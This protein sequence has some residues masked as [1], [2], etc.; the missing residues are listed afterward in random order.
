MPQCNTQHFDV[1][2]GI[3]HFLLHSVTIFSFACRS[4]FC[5]HQIFLYHPHMRN[6][7]FQYYVI[8]HMYTAK[9][10]SVLKQSPAERRLPQT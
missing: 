6:N 3:C 7:S 8:N 5:D 10:E 4:V 9:T 2:R 1:F